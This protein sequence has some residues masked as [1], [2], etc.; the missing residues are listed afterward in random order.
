MDTLPRHFFRTNASLPRSPR[1]TNRAGH[2]PAALR[3]ALHAL[4]LT[5]EHTSIGVHPTVAYVIYLALN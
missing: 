3:L 4:K 1:L 5:A 2:D